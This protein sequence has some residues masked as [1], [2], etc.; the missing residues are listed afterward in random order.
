MKR[1]LLVAS[2]YAPRV[3]GLE[4]VTAELAGGLR[5]RG[6]AVQVITSRYPRILPARE[7][8]AGI[9]VRRLYFVLARWNN[10]RRGRADLFFAGLWFTPFA[11]LQLLGEVMR[12]KP[13]VVNFHFVGAPAFFVL[14]VHTLWG[15]RLVVSL[16]G[17]DVEG[18]DS[19]PRFDTRLFRAL[20]RRADAVTACSRALLDEAAR[21][22]PT[23][24]SKGIVIYNGVESAV[25]EEHCAAGSYWAAVGR[26]VL[27]KGFDVLLRALAM[28]Q[29]QRLEF[30]IV[31]D[32]PERTR[33]QE[34]A[35]ALGVAS[36]VQ[37]RG[38]LSRDDALHVIQ[39]SRGVVIP[40]R[41]EPFGMVALEAMAAGKP[42]VA[43]RVGG[44]PEVLE[45]AEA[46]LVPADDA[47]AL[48]GAIDRVEGELARTAAYG[49]RN[50]QRAERFSVESMVDGYVR[51]YEPPC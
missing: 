6:H 13:D 33:L 30:V 28:A 9:E 12:F 45:G 24:R 48:A 47:D 7:T 39:H 17:D 35:H 41:Q 8:I 37:W 49:C 38:A 21:I 16:H 29:N 18:L 46:I 3:G 51:A 20:V 34:L 32:G 44:L 31:G 43:T 27:K 26:L 22:E 14:A 23:A 10:L 50:R 19:R 25:A 42:V 5:E 15:A 11:T 1:V 40:S 2:S 36:R 4:T